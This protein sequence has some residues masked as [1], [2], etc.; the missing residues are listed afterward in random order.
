VAKHFG[1]KGASVFWTKWIGKGK[2]ANFSGR[3]TIEDLPTSHIG[4]LVTFALFRVAGADS[5]A[6]FDGDPPPE[7]YVDVIKLREN[8]K[9]PITGPL[10]FSVERPAGYYYLGIRLIPLYERDGRM[11]A[12]VQTF[13]PLQKPFVLPS[14]N[15]AKLLIRISWRPIPKEN[16][17]DL[18]VVEPGSGIRRL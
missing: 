8:D 11:V 9:A 7:K 1:R 16:L 10:E 17:V 3:I 18:A 14:A 6:P 15:D 2:P 13:F 12:E 4:C 5:E